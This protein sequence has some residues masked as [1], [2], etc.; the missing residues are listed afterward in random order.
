MKS[1]IIKFNKT[2]EYFLVQFTLL[3]TIIG[4]KTVK[5]KDKAT[6]F[7]EDAVLKNENG[8]EFKIGSIRCAE[9][10]VFMNWRGIT[11]DDI[12]IETFDAPEQEFFNDPKSLEY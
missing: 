8:A 11:K 4:V 5:E 9:F 12:T 3:N 1:Q 10:V 7:Q 6:M 2:G